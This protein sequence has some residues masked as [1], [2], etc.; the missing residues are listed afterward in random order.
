MK[1]VALLTDLGT[2]ECLKNSWRIKGLIFHKESEE[3]CESSP[4]N[5]L[6][7]GEGIQREPR[8]KYMHTRLKASEN[9]V[10]LGRIGC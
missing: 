2:F 1:P 4:A 10:I 7:R 8:S 9:L 6:G 3:T 5:A